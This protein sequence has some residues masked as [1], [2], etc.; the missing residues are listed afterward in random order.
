MVSQTADSAAWSCEAPA[1]I[2]VGWCVYVQVLWNVMYPAS[3]TLAPALTTLAIT[4]VYFGIMVRSLCLHAA[5]GVLPVVWSVWTACSCTWLEALCLQ[6]QLVTICLSF[7]TSM[8]TP[9]HSLQSRG[10]GQGQKV[11]QLPGT[12]STLLFALSPLPQLVRRLF[13]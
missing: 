6:R 10:P 13:V 5:C 1:C 2:L 11:A 8:R 7:R 9:A 4:A 12:A 3:Q